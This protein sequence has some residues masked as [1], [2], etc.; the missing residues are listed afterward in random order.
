VRREPPHQVDPA[1]VAQVGEFSRRQHEIEDRPVRPK[2]DRIGVPCNASDRLAVAE[3]APR[4]EGTQAMPLGHLGHEALHRRCQGTLVEIGPIG[5]VGADGQRVLDEG[6][7]LGVRAQRDRALGRPA[8][9]HS[10]LGG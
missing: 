1:A 3:L 7:R 10:G 6:D 9:G 5:R 2:T 4:L 8:E